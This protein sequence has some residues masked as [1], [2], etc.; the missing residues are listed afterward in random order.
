MKNTMK[1]VVKHPEAPKSP[2]PKASAK[3][4]KAVAKSVS[5][6]YAC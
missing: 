1:K 4:M 5:S 2:S 6:R 3:A